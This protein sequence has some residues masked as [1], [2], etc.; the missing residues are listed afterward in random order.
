MKVVSRD[1]IRLDSK[2][3]QIIYAMVDE[4][5]RKIINSVVL[6]RPIKQQK[7]KAVAA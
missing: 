2:R 4:W 7:P 5:G 3:V 6:H 1:E